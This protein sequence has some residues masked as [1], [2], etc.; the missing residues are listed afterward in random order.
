L[1]LGIETTAHTFGCAVVEERGGKCTVHSNEKKAYVTEKG[2]MRPCDVAD[3]HALH[4]EQILDAALKKANKTIKDINL[5]SFSQS[6]GIG[7]MLRIGCM[8]AKSLSRIHKIPIVGV[9]HCIA[10]LEIGNATTGAKDPVMLYASGANTQVIAYEGKKYR[11]F[12]ETLDTGVGNFLDSF[13]RY[14]GFGFPGGPKIAEYAKKGRWI[15]LPYTVKGMDTAF[16]GLL[17]EVKKMYDNKV[18]VEDLCYSIQEVVFSELLEVSERAMAHCG[19][20]EL[21]LG[22]GVAC[23]ER[24]VEM[25]KKMCD[26]RG[27]KLFVP[28]RQFLVDNAAMIAWQGILQKKDATLDVSN[29]DIEPYLRTDDIN[30]TW[31]A[32]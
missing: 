22:G 11:V 6:P 25:S 32:D 23:N 29:I 21:L 5:I 8:F 31:R 16:S 17:T 10:H 24:L 9:N 3:H 7:Q 30:V 2:G 13:A 12:G 27:A 28:Q 19:K 4:C 26:E 14:V 1:C 15:E 20:T 18:P